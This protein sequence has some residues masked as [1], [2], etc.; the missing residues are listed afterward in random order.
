MAQYI[1]VS[2]NIIK[3]EQPLIELRQAGLYMLIQAFL[4]NPNF[5]NANGGLKNALLKHCTNGRYSFNKSWNDLKNF[6]LLKRCRMPIELNRFFDHYILLSNPNTAEP[7]VKNLTYKEGQAYLSANPISFTEIFK[8][9]SGAPFKVI[10][11]EKLSLEA[12]ALYMV[13]LRL[14][15]IAS[16]TDFILTKESI[17]K[18][19]NEGISKFNRIWKELKE[20]GYLRL[21]QSFNKQSKKTQYIYTLSETAEPVLNKATVKKPVPE[22]VSHKPSAANYSREAFKRMIRLKL[23]VDTLSSWTEER[24]SSNDYLETPYYSKEDV[25]KLVTIIT[26]ICCSTCEHIKINKIH[27][28]LDEVTQTLLENLSP[29]VAHNV[30]NNIL[31]KGNQKKASASNIYIF[32]AIYNECLKVAF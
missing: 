3:R 27:L 32:T 25:D 6:G 9:Y 21:E 7:A 16:N 8:D 11:D 18:T 17:F 29:E 1:K 13:I 23:D 14:S 26:N 19:C 4:S 28:P 12:K 20:T 31:L 10:M 30:L 22:V 5:K 24:F 2:N 15:L